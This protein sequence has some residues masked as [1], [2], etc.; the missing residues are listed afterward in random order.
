[1]RVYDFGWVRQNRGRGN[2]EEMLMRL[3]MHAT[4]PALAEHLLGSAQSKGCIR[5]SATLNDFINRYGLL[6]ADYDQAVQKGEYFWVL[7][8]DRV[9]NEIR[10]RYLITIDSEVNIRPDWVLMKKVFISFV[11]ALIRIRIF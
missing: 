1:M 8:P 3:Q 2:G 9:A 10:G 5:I 6:D 11:R 7:R 4:D